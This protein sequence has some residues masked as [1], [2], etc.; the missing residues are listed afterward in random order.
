MSLYNE[1]QILKYLDREL[2][3]EQ[4][5]AFEQ[6]LKKDPE[7]KA[8]VEQL[9]S[10]NEIFNANRLE[11]APDQ[12]SADVMAEISGFSKKNYY[13]P[14]GLSSSSGFLM[15]SGIVTALVAFL[16]LINGGY[17]D[18]QEL[19]PATFAN[20]LFS[21]SSF[22]SK[23]LNA[24]TITNAMLVIYGGFALVIL[25]RLVLNPFFRKRTRQLGYN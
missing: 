23:L 11:K 3:P 10:T 15:A 13:R 17:I 5:K 21:T 12:L 22:F 16:S 18:M 4:V 1:E 25:D 6:E 20:D 19:I 24:R 9:I 2:T 7:L 14:N 8:T